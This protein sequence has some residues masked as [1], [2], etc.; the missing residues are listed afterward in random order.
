MEK[1]KTDRHEVRAKEICCLVHG[2]KDH[3][4]ELSD[5]IVEALRKEREEAQREIIEAKEITGLQYWL[6]TILFLWEDG[7]SKA[8]HP[9]DIEKA[10]EVCLGY[11]EFAAKI[12]GK[13]HV[14][15][16]MYVDFTEEEIRRLKENSK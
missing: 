6:N 7:A 11:F 15:N 14:G 10:H 13:K 4:C 12:Y 9:N 5:Q 1:D 3:V 2:R 8:D 16:G